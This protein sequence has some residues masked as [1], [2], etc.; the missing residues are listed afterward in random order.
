[1][2]GKF[3]STALNENSQS[4]SYYQV[5]QNLPVPIKR[6]TPAVE[7]RL[8]TLA[9][10]APVTAPLLTYRPISAICHLKYPI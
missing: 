9:I 10:L 7:K 3:R 6:I 4:D 2:H 1:M 8:F 5:P